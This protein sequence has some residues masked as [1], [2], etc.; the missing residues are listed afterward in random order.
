MSQG[1]SLPA[2]RSQLPMLTSLP[3]LS[4]H[5]CSCEVN[6]VCKMSVDETEC[7]DCCCGGGGTDYRVPSECA[8]GGLVV[9]ELPTH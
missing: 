7:S 8:G 1:R 2:I 4:P 6:N 5:S 3:H 9:D